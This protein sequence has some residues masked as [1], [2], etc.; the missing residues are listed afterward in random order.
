[1]NSEE[2]KPEPLLCEETRQSG[3]PRILTLDIESSP[4]TVRTFNLWGANIDKAKMIEPSRML[5]FA[6]KWYGQDDI[7][8]SGLHNDSRTAM[9]DLS[10]QLCDEA[11]WLI[12][13]NGKRFDE[14]YLRKEWLLAG[15][16]PP[17]PWKSIDL[18]K[19][20]RSQFKMAYNSLAWA[21]QQLGLDLKESH[22][23]FELWVKCM[24]DDPAAWGVMES[25]CR[26]DVRITEQLYERLLPFIPNHPSHGAF[27][28]KDD[29]CPSCG[30]AAQLIREGHAFTSTGKFQRWRCSGC[31]KWSRSS[32]RDSGT[33][34]VQLAS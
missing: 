21:C 4:H 1:M 16:P 30:S 23:G 17:S 34:I 5:C 8:Y 13:Y 26:N 27:E 19:T 29:V 31:G 20:V 22:E 9:I 2:V 15:L 11:D 12:T 18:Y 32:K 25:Y 6:A 7:I 28:G 14:P 3:R 24:N 10:W 33:N